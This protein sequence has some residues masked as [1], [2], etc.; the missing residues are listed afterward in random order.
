MTSD[1]VWNA[2]VSVSDSWTQLTA[3]IPADAKFVALNYA[4]TTSLYY[5]YVDSLVISVSADSEACFAPSITNVT[6]GVDAITVNYSADTTVEAAITTG[7]V[8]PS[9]ITGTIVAAGT[10]T[11]TFSGL[12]PN[13][14]YTIGLRTVCGG[15]NYS[16]WACQ[17]ITTTEAPCDVPANVAYSDV[18]YTSAVITWDAGNASQW[19]VRVANGDDVEMVNTTAPTAN[20]DHLTPGTQYNVMVRAICSATNTSDWS[21][22]VALTTLSCVTPT[23]LMASNVTTTTATLN[24]VSD[25]SSWEMELNNEV[26]TINEKPYQL[27]GLTPGTNYTVKV[28]AICTD[29]LMSEWSAPAYFTT[30]QV[31]IEDVDDATIALYPNPASTTVTIDLNGIEGSAVVSIIDLNGRRCGEW[32]AENGKVVV[33]LTGFARGAYFVRVTGENTSAIRK[34]VV[35]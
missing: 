23:N 26:S 27:S 16:A 15:D 34:L 19:E 17:T 3:T 35:K 1:F 30:E 10:T 29:S 13:T 32:M 21:S 9:S 14:Q 2:A 33:D 8:W 24:W 12:A 25:A 20:L 5:L 18:D 31:G 7:S 4:P 28:R 11:Y 22:T 6:P